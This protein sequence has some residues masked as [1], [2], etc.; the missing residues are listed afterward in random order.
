MTF[1][2]GTADRQTHPHSAGF[3]RE[4]RLEQ[5]LANPGVNALA[6]VFHNDFDLLRGLSFGHDEYAALVSARIS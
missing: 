1:D 6:V 5:A 3:R 4:K 2:D